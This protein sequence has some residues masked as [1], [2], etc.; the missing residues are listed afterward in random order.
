LT[1]TDD[2]DDDGDGDE[3]G[4][5]GLVV[6]DDEEEGDDDKEDEEDSGDEED[7]LEALAD[8]EREALMRNT[9]VVHTMLNKVPCIYLIVPYLFD[10]LMYMAL[11]RFTNCHSP[12][13]IPPPLPSLHG[14]KLASPVLS[15]PSLSLATSKHGGIRHMTCSRLHLSIMKLLMISQQTRH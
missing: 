15:V 6:L 7:P 11:L 9:E 1:N 8:E 12:L 13:F 4:M 5:P 3:N 2:A 10:V 14:V